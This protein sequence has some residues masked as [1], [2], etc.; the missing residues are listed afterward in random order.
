MKLNYIL[1]LLLLF[2]QSIVLINSFNY[3][4]ILKFVYKNSNLGIEKDDLQKMS[5]LSKIIYEYDYNSPNN[6]K[7]NQ[8]Q[9]FIISANL[10]ENKQTNLTFNFIQKNNIYFDTTQ[11]VTFLNNDHFVKKTKKYFTTLNEKFPKSEI[12]GYFC[13]KTRLHALILINH[14][15]EEIIV[16]F[17]GSQYMDEWFQNLFVYEK[18]LKFNKNYSIHSGIYEMYTRNNLNKNIIYI[19]KNLYSFFP[20]Y[21]KIITGHSK[22]STNSILLGFELIT[23][24]DAK[25]EYEIYSFGNPPIFNY[26]LADFLHHTEKLKI[27]NVINKD[28][29]ITSFPLPFHYQIGNEILLDEKNIIFVNQKNPYKISFFDT[30]KHFYHCFLQ[31]D[32]TIYIENIK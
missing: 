2:D 9:N 10:D 18:T 20:N 31:H 4:K 8:N 7:K 23:L 25:Y 5:I 24:L 28:D 21:R 27:Y 29:I 1:Y 13:N 22:G 15:L 3:K 19:L 11:H 17:R 14:E 16:V 6:I 12:Y 26:K 32:I 30:M